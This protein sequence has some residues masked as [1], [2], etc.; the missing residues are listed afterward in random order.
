M[1]TKVG[2]V[3]LLLLL[4]AFVPHTD[5]THYSLPGKPTEIKCRSPEKE[6]FTCWWKPGSDGG[7]PTTYALYYRKEGSD[8]VH[9]C[10]DYHTAGKN[11]CFF[12]KN[13]TLIWVS[14][15]ITV[16]ATNALGKT[17]SDPQDI[18]VVYIVQP[19][20]PEKLEVT[21]M[22]DQGWPF[23]RVS[24]EPPRKADTRS[25]W[26]TL[27]YELR[28][29]LEDE[30]SEWENHAAGQQKMFNIF[31][32]RSGGTYL[33]QVRCKPDHGFW[34]E[35]SSTSYVKVPEYLHR[36]KSVW[37]LVLVFSAF[38]LLLLTWLI[39]MNSHSLKHCMLPP[40][41]GPK[42]KGF[43]KQLLKS[44]KSDEVFSA[45]VVSDFP[46]TTSNYEDLLV[47]YLEVY[48]P[49]QQ[50]LMVDKG[51]DH[52]GCLKSI[53]SASDSDSGR[54]SCD[55]D[56]LLMDKS[57][58]P[59]EEQQQQNQE[60]DQIG[61]ETQGP[62]EAWEKEAMPCANED[63]VS[64]DA[65]S[66][67]VKTWPSV[68]SPVT[69]Y[70]PLD[71]HNSLEMHKQ[72]CLS[73]TQF[74]PGSPSSDH[75][76]KEALQSSYWE[77]CFNNNQP[78]PQTE[79][80]P[81]LQAHSDRNISAVND[82]NAPTGLLLPTRMTEYVEVQRVNEENKVLLHPIPS[83]HSRE[84]ACPWVGQRDDYSKV[85]GV[86]SD[87]G[88]LLQREVVEEESMEMAGAAESCYTSS[89]AFTTPKQTA[90]SPVALPVQDERVLAVSGY[91]DTATVFSV[92]T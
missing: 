22:K 54:G 17:Y 91:V 53:G 42:I 64:P 55:S 29:K 36:E 16:V 47:E 70:S 35:W 73:N 67:K 61:K 43:D 1:M 28:V 92:H 6:T 45:L 60:G 77:V 4:P 84:K 26:I 10:P 89:I 5:G 32:L 40:V 34:S 69:P 90:C 58:A 3:L 46:P 39:H 51:K 81:Q 72:H 57:G 37:I 23:L 88:L 49:E 86:D 8:V 30:E 87:N 13:N 11:S 78:Y 20:P 66:E 79:V 62:K 74:P 80:H 9:E 85:K 68:F 38:I 71:P 2:E 7:L 27:I 12:N 65:S 41:P 82:R 56:N 15:N 48:M 59:K 31:S 75:Y 18:D 44:G 19:H 52:D 21:V 33:I 63:V 14:Y 76:I 24:W 83:G 50:E 25:G